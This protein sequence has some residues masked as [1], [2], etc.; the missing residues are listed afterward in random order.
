MAELVATFGCGV[1]FGAALYISLVQHPASMEAG[2]TVAERFFPPMYRRAAVMQ[3]ASAL[4]ATAAGVVAWL[5]RGD[6]WWLVGAVVLF[7]VIPLTLL[8][9]KPINDRL[10]DPIR[11]PEAPDRER[12]LRRWA[13]RHAVRS[14]L[15]GMAFG[16]FLW[17]LSLA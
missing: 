17:R 7:A 12:L 6:L 4:L 2:V 13:A 5:A 8:W 3:A 1:F 14:A 9:I 10:L 15:G 16:I 11:D